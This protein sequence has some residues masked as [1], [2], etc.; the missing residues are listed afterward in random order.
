MRYCETGGDGGQYVHY[1]E[2]VFEL[3]ASVHQQPPDVFQSSGI[4]A[5]V[6][7]W[8]HRSRTYRWR[9]TGYAVGGVID[10]FISYCG[11][12]FEAGKIGGDPCGGG[13]RVVQGPHYNIQLFE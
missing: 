4:V 12:Y 5:S 9:F 11:G 7:M 6:A 1:T 8:K 13:R 2:V 3:V 10:V